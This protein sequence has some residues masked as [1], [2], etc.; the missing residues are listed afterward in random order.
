M[1]DDE[2]DIGVRQASRR[3]PQVLDAILSDDNDGVSSPPPPSGPIP[4]SIAVLYGLDDG[5]EQ[6]PAAAPTAG[7]SEGESCCL[8]NRCVIRGCSCIKYTPRSGR[9]TSVGE[10]CTCG[11]GRAAHDHISENPAL[12]SVRWHPRV[13]NRLSSPFS[14]R[15]C[16]RYL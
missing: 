13:Q 7:K 15:S 16:A 2:P 12:P 9:R 10:P 6:G 14:N 1:S 5:V 11:H 3:R 4:R 8:S